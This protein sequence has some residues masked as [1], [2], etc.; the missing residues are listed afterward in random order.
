MNKDVEKL[1]KD[2][3]F[4][5]DEETWEQ[6]ANRVSS[7]FF[8]VFNDIKE[9]KF[10]PSS[11]TL[12][13]SNTK[14]ERLGTLSSCFP[15]DIED[16]IE[17]IYE[18]QKEAAIVTKLGGGIGYDFT[19]LRGSNEQI[20]SIKRDSS[21]PLPFINVFNAT[22]D[23][24]QQGG[25]RRGAGMAMLSIYHP[26]IIDF[27]NAKKNLQNFTRFNFSIKIDDEFYKKLKETPDAQHF[28]KNVNNELE[29]A[30]Q[31]KD[32]KLITI[33]Q[34]WDMIIQQAWSVA[35]PGV[36]NESIAYRQ[37]TVTNLSQTVISN[38]CQEFVNIPYASCNLGS[39]NLS[40]FVHGKKFDWEALHNT[41]INAVTFL[42][43]V[44]DVNKF[45]IKSIE[46]ITKKIRPIGLGVMGLAHALYMKEVPYN[47]ERAYNFIDEVMRY[48]TLLSMKTSIE[49]AK[50][51][52]ESYEA[53]DYDLF[54]KANERFFKHNKCR[55]II[56]SDLIKDI[57]K[58]G[59][60][61]SCFTSIAPTGSIAFIAET[62][63]GIEPVFAL[64]YARKIEKVNKE[65][66]I[67]YIS[68]PI[69][70]KYIESNFTEIQQKEILKNIAENNGSC[71][72]CDLIPKEMKDV[73]KVAGDLT[74]L[75]HLNILK[76]AA[77]NTSLSVSKTV[78]LPNHATKEEIQE[79]YLK[80][81]EMGI[82]GV[83]VYRDGCREGVLVHSNGNGNGIIERHAPKRPKSLPCEIYRI[84]YKGE[85]W[86]SF[87]GLYKNHPYEI[88][89]GKV[90]K[91]NLPKSISNGEIIKFKSGHYRFE[92]KEEEYFI[93]HIGETFNN[94][95]ERDALARS[96]SGHLRHGTPIK[97]VIDMLNKSEGDITNYAKALAR[98][99]K[100]Y[101]K[102]GETASGMCPECKG[103]L[104]YKQGCVECANPTCS[105]SKCS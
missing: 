49:F 103:K 94:E 78:N 33:K 55:E 66:D 62:S 92:N 87:I 72:K 2:R 18:A 25:V 89:L 65:Y 79:V 93:D 75:E 97:Y 100:N 32:G 20:K 99:L 57:K 23:G 13:N 38:P 15:M 76:A 91:V 24:I 102:D 61:N 105:F 67:V 85:D 21:G 73:F 82:I 104:I 52:K 59:I 31:D 47:S 63:G 50:K 12:M 6:L 68:D 27:I 58:Y 5:K 28:V 11:P 96:I 90:N 7:I 26:N 77:Q 95:G 51:T 40:K 34:L 30:L 48:I 54:I 4:L 36:F 71:S 88:F 86:I 74:P 84:K 98:I 46:K 10:I 14:G 8:D 39:I 44:I 81:H 42:D 22:L 37:C 29:Y 69:F 3:Y 9:M 41:I 80:A 1:L 45:P 53:F 64:T 35:E 17:G 70:Q 83:T 19:K 60:R 56:T 43:A 16:S 101:I